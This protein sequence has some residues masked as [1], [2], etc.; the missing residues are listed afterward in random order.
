M[1]VPFQSAAGSALAGQQ[2]T[3]YV[4]EQVLAEGYM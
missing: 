4:T 1:L 3:V 2:R